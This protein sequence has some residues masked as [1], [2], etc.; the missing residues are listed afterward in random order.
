MELAIA[1]R[2]GAHDIRAAADQLAQRLPEPLRPLAQLAFN[3]RWSWDPDGPAIYAAIDPERWSAI[4]GDPVRLLV[5]ASPAVR[6]RA[7]ADDALVARIDHLA[8]RVQ[9]D[10]QRPF[11]TGLDPERPVA[12]L[13]SEYGVHQSLPIY[14]GGLGVLAGDILKESSDLALPSVA[15][16]L[17]YRYGYFHQ[18]LDVTG[19]QHEHWIE[20][21]PYLSPQVL[22]RDDAGE[23]IQ[24]TVPVYGREVHARVWRVD[25]GRVPL[26]LLDANVPA[27]SPTDRWITGRL[28]DGNPQVRLAQYAMLGIGAI[29][30]LQA[31]GV[32]P[33]L[34]HL[35][36][37]H[38]ALAPLELV[39]A[40]VADG[41]SFADAASEIKHRCAFTTH[42]PVS[43]GNET[44][45]P[46][47]FLNAL[48]DLPRRLGTDADGLLRLA[49]KYPDDD[50]EEP[51]MTP[52]ALRLARTTNAVSA[53]HGDVARA[54]WNPMFPGEVDDVPITHVTNGVHVPT[55][56]APPM[57]RLFDR[58][59]GEGWQTR[60]ADPDT[61]KAVDDIP[62][63]ELWEVRNACRAALVE[64]ARERTMEDRVRRGIPLENIER[65]ATALDP[66]V[67]T[68][69]F[70]RRVASYKRLYLL[71]LDP[72]RAIR[73]LDEPNPVQLLLAGKAHP[74]DDGAKGM[75]RDLFNLRWTPQVISRVEFLEDYDLD[76]GF[77]L[78]TGC[79]VWLNL[80]RP[81][82]EAS[83]TSGMKSV[84]NGG[85]NVSVL[86]GWWAEGYDGTNGWALSGDVDDDHG[87]QDHEHVQAMFRLFEDEVAPLYYDRGADGVPHG[88]VARMKA[89][90]R[91]LAWRFSATRMMSE[92]RDGIYQE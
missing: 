49:R 42:T 92:Y 63:T 62:D 87:R 47:R 6:R 2:P 84:L 29:R 16:G 17:R 36:E 14:S 50:G 41:A 15:V 3:Y 67:L 79:D 53:R 65:A 37:G 75:V 39:A 24:I 72:D 54:M 91:T 11:A 44:Y 59:L 26:Y 5:E 88:W 13:C 48:D 12:F 90:L 83:G 52:V 7:A 46:E 71:G 69:G 57:T 89:S 30:T 43:A 31:M 4:E 38:P 78:T 40:R 23:P 35:N 32:D 28:Y 27:N 85:L 82:L 66:G 70:A 22:V 33:G 68:I 19:W 77:R 9:A 80:P 64:W 21:D 25:V 1:A 8:G 55:W 58:Y 56:T 74:S 81:P 20:S 61:W 60:A 73:L 18:R 45:P 51:G 34:L 10:L 86:D 76:I